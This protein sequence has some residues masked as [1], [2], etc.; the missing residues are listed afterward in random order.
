MSLASIP[1][2][3]ALALKKESK[4]KEQD[5]IRGGDGGEVTTVCDVTIGGA[6]AG[7]IHRRLQ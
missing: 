1:F 6:K 3:F 4:S 2:F 5:W 7:A